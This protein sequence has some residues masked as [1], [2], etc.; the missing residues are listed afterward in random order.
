MIEPEVY[1]R[2]PASITL[3]LGDMCLVQYALKME[4]ALCKDLAAAGDEH[5]LLRCK[6]YES[7]LSEVQAAGKIA[8]QAYI[9][10][11]DSYEQAWKG[12]DYATD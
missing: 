12:A 8:E 6:W 10:A 11:W 7:L 4:L 2:F 3:S 9:E 5:A 1:D